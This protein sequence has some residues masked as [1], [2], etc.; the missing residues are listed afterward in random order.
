MKSQLETLG[1]CLLDGHFQC[2]H[3]LWK[4]GVVYCRCLCV[5]YN[6]YHTPQHNLML[7]RSQQHPMLLIVPRASTHRILPCSR[8]LRGRRREGRSRRAGAR[9]D[10][11]GMFW[12]SQKERKERA[13]CPAC[14]C[15][16]V[17]REAFRAAKGSVYLRMHAG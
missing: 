1:K 3:K 12:S 8:K 14:G 5:Q 4:H 6:T 9:L 7:S 10:G 15:S 17:A 11:L 13:T 2:E 16:R